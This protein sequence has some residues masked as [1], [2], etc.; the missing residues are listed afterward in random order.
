[1]QTEQL[2]SITS[3]VTNKK[4]LTKGRRCFYRFVETKIPIFIQNY[5]EMLSSSAAVTESSL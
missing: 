1:M 2:D 3:K 4:G 5:K